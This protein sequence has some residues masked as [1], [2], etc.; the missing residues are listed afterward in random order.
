MNARKNLTRLARFMSRWLIAH[1]M[2]GWSVIAQIECAHLT[3]WRGIPAEDRLRRGYLWMMNRSSPREL[4]RLLVTGEL[5]TSEEAAAE[6]LLSQC[7]ETLRAGSINELAVRWDL[8]G[9]EA[10]LN[11]FKKPGKPL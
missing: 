9:D 3:G 6:S 5:M 1:G 4:R 11:W 2:D 7:R 10:V 8:L